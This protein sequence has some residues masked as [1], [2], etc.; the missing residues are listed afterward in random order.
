MVKWPARHICR[1]RQLLLLQLYNSYLSL[2]LRTS[3]PLLRP[4]KLLHSCRKYLAPLFASRKSRDQHIGNQGKP[5][6]SLP[7]GD[8]G[9]A[10]VD[11]TTTKQSLSDNANTSIGQRS[12][13]G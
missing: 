12:L 6:I 3:V 1:S 2:P 13:T 9:L 5:I 10:L 11:L 4:R 8:Q 7:R